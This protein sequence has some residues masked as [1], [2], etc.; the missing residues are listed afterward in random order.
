M[1]ACIFAIVMVGCPL[2]G[3]TGLW[4]GIHSFS[5]EYLMRTL[6]LVRLQGQRRHQTQAS[7]L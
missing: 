2:L 1:G 4:R 7:S 3:S 5:Q 6:P